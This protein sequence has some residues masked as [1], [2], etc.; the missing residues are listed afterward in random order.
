M[1]QPFPEIVFHQFLRCNSV[2]LLFV[3][4]YSAKNKPTYKRPD[5]QVYFV[6]LNARVMTFRDLIRQ[7]VCFLWEGV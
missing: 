5:K 6:Q 1:P 4:R 7:K 2:H 3:T